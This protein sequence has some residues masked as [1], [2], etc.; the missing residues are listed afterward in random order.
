MLMIKKILNF[1]SRLFKGSSSSSKNNGSARTTDLYAGSGT[2][3]ALSQVIHEAFDQNLKPVLYFHA[4]WCGAAV[5]FK[6]G[7]SDARMQAAL[8][9]S[10]LIIIDSDLDMEQD[11][12]SEAYHI[13]HVP[14]F[15]RV[16]RDGSAIKAITGAEWGADV[17]ENMAPV[18]KT[19][20]A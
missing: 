19:F 12:I 10:T 16:N 17:I 13:R 11:K 8:E 7:L 4:D 18:M 2:K 6:A 9:G 15:I 5:K 3:K 20:L 1:F 14:T